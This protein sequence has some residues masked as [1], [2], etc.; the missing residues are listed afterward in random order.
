MLPAPLSPHVPSLP[1]LPSL[2]TSRLCPFSCWFTGGWLC[3]CFRILWVSLMNSP[4]RLEVFPTATTPTDFFTA[5]G[6]ESLVSHT[7]TLGFTVC[8][9]PLLFPWACLGM[10]VRSLAWSASHCLAVHP[11][12][13]VARC[14]LYPSYNLGECFFNSLGVGLPWKYFSF[15]SGCSLFLTWL[16]SFFLVVWGSQAFLPTS[17]SWPELSH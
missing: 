16:L 11:L 6:F 13:P 14:C 12:S 15:S 9:A 10:N 4:V 17:P 2:L 5:W 7:D 1:S 8:L 3:V